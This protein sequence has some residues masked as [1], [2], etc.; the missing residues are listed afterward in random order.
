MP[1]ARSQA[2]N[3]SAVTWGEASGIESAPTPRDMVWFSF[4]KVLKQNSSFNHF[5]GSAHKVVPQWESSLPTN[6]YGK[7]TQ[8]LEAPGQKGKKTFTEAIVSVMMVKWPRS[9]TNGQRISPCVRVY[10]LYLQGSQQLIIKNRVTVLFK[11]KREI[12]DLASIGK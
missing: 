7:A 8:H 10:S 11:I 12:W 2:V 5:R 1:G 6:G 9:N 3:R 4:L